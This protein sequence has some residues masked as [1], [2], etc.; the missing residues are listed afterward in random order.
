MPCRSDLLDH[1]GL[2]APR[3]AEARAVA[4]Q[5]QRLRQ[6]VGQ[7]HA[8]LRSRQSPAPHHIVAGSGPY[9]LK[10][11]TRAADARRHPGRRMRPLPAEPRPCSRPSP[12]QHRA[13]QKRAP[14]SRRHHR[15]RRW[16]RCAASRFPEGPAPHLFDRAAVRIEARHRLE[17][18]L[19]P[20][21]QHV[22]AIVAAE[23]MHRLATGQHIGSG[24]N[25]AARAAGRQSA[26]PDPPS[27]WRGRGTGPPCRRQ[28][29]TSPT[30]RRRTVLSKECST[31]LLTTASNTP[32][33]KGNGSPA[34]PWL[35]S[36]SQAFVATASRLAW[37]IATWEK[38][39]PPTWN[40]RRASA[41]AS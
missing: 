27:N 1:A 18:E 10:R 16:R 35:N 7:G 8:T 20:V 13:R 34:S 37:S 5:A 12:R 4:G 23:E 38:S 33:S 41:S 26:A 17:Q 28:R 6:T 15:G 40:P 39:M 14:A 30:M 36:T 31:R 25:A 21:G 32:S 19:L 29:P 11:R 24:A 3:V 22:L 2:V 9:P